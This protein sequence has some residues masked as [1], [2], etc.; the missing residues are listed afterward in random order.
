MVLAL[1]IT[2]IAIVGT[3]PNQFMQSNTCVSPI[4]AGSQCTIRVVFAPTSKGAKTATLKVTAGSGA[5]TTTAPL[6]GTGI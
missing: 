3:N 1:P 6:T 4:A 2:S 5:I